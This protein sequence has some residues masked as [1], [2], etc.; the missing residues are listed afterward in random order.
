MIS[1]DGCTHGVEFVVNVLQVVVELDDMIFR[2]VQHHLVAVVGVE[3]KLPSTVDLVSIL[4]DNHRGTVIS[5]EVFHD[6]LAEVG[7]VPFCIAARLRKRI[8]RGS[9]TDWYSAV[10]GCLLF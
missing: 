2:N 1:G 6:D 8:R 3:D 7:V 10:T 5:A 9:T 4:L